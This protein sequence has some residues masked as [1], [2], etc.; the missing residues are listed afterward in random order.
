MFVMA[1][2]I[3]YT[4]RAIRPSDGEGFMTA[5]LMTCMVTDKIISSSGGGQNAICP[6]VFDLLENDEEVRDL[7]RRRVA[8]MTANDSD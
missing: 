3:G 4:L 7:I 6:E 8:A 1:K 2:N 5:A